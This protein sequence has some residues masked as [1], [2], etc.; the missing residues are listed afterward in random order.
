MRSLLY[1]CVSTILIQT[2]AFLQPCKIIPKKVSMFEKPKWLDES[3][4][5][6]FKEGS[7]PRSISLT[8]G[9]SGF[10]TDLKVGFVAILA[11]N[12]RR[13]TSVVI[14][15]QD[16]DRVKSPEAL[17]CVQLAGG[18]D[19]GTPILPPDTLAKLVAKDDDEIQYLRR[20]VSLSKVTVVP[21]ADFSES[22]DDETILNNTPL[23]TPERDQNIKDGKEKVFK[24]IQS[25][26]NLD[27]VTLDQVYD[28]MQLHTDKE[29]KVD[30]EAFTN[31]LEY[32]RQQRKPPSSSK[33]QFELLVNILTDDGVKQTTVTT[34]KAIIALGLAM[35]YKVEVHV[36]DDCTLLEDENT[37]LDRFPL[38]QTKYELYEEAKLMDG[39]IP[40]MFNRANLDNDQKE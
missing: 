20:R 29:G 31:I 17:T 39:F 28:A 12:D 2:L 7:I 18:L 5:D 22:D 23:S 27:D 1:L 11:N 34:N 32:L 30:R 21:N 37:L 35:R 19:L 40:N 16:K 3:M 33:L 13:W 36:S 15:P 6:E 24:A 10:S 9:I 4:D 38:F 14:S 26:P 25:L 8:S